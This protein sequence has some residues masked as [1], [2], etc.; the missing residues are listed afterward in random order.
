MRLAKLLGAFATPS[1]HNF[2]LFIWYSF[3]IHLGFVVILF[4]VICK[5]CFLGQLG[6]WRLDWSL[7]NLFHYLTLFYLFISFPYT[8]FLL[9]IY[10]FT[11]HFLCLFVSVMFLMGSLQIW[12]SKSLQNGIFPITVPP[13][14]LHFF[15]TW[16]W[17]YKGSFD[18]LLY[19][20]LGAV[21]QGGQMPLRIWQKP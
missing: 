2:P 15:L 13:F 4:S 19:H 14:I 21:S 3:I 7:C 16:L 9:V 8:L 12:K 17:I 11:C 5:E 10:L 20:T 1:L 6:F 18:M